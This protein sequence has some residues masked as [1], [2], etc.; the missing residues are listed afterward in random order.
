MLLCGLYQPD[1]PARGWAKP[2]LAR[3]AGN[4]GKVRWRTP[5]SFTPTWTDRYS[6]VIVT[7]GDGGAAGLRVDDGQIVWEYAAPPASPTFSTDAG[8]VLTMDGRRADPFGNFHLLGGRL[9]F[10]QGERRLF[11][12]DAESGHVLWARWA[13]GARLRQPAPDGRFF[14]IVPGNAD[15]LLVQTSGGRRWLL[16]AAT[17]NLLHDD[18]T[19]TE[20]WPRAPVV[21]PDG[22]VCLTTD[23]RTIVC[24]DP[25]SGREVWTYTLPGVTTRT[26]EAPRLAAGPDALLLAWATNIG[27]RL[28]RLDPATGKR[29]WP[30]PPLVN[31]SELDVA[32]WSV[33]ADAIYGVQDRVLFARSLRDGAVL[34]EQPLTGPAGRW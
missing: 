28:Q 26:G 19:S 31:V 21:L 7:A 6:G 18:P 8:T 13:P 30:D 24:L 2:S 34:W 5:L 23:A 25:A 20:P 17:G 15:I 12:L 10:V 32:G 1:A 33:D 27:W 29:A 14:H 9:C 3:R 16:D 4:T 11:A 22:G